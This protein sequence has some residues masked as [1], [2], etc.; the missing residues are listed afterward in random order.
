MA[1][2]SKRSDLLT[3]G[4]VLNQVRSE[5]DDISISKIRFLEAEGL[6]V[7]SRTK[8]GYR[9][10]S[11]SDVEKLRYI[12]RMQRDHYLP[13]KVIKE[14]IE[15][16][17]RG[18]KPEIDEIEKP[19]VPSALVDLNQLGIKKSNIRVTREELISNTSITDQDLKE[20]EDYG[21]IKVLADKRHYDDIAVKT[22]RVIAALS[23]F[24][25][26]P[27]HLKFLKSGS[28]RESSLIKQVASPMSRSK[29]PDAGEQ[30]LEM[31]RE[32]SN[33]TNQLHFILVSSTLDEE[34]L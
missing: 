1:I 17:D 21:L 23:G 32:I 34:I 30:A 26:E 4:E 24:G 18:L 12:L 25:L 29:R 9:K 7:P 33:L 2:V 22:A 20:S 11:S 3:I 27:R 14:H 8:S 5:F 6:I 16:I 31:M 10:F 28:D 13:L 19:K 15:A